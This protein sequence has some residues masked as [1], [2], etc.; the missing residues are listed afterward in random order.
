MACKVFIAVYTNQTAVS[1][2]FLPDQIRSKNVATDKTSVPI[3]VHVVCLARET[4]TLIPNIV[5][6]IHAAILFTYKSGM[7]H[8]PNHTQ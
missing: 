1:N 2:D 3:V 4:K 7:I 5:C 8:T 6:K